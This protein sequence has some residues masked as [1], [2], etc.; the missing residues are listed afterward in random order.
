MARKRVVTRTIEECM[1]E[2]KV[3]YTIGDDDVVERETFSLGGQVD[4]KKALT[5]A[6]NLYNRPASKGVDENGKEIDIPE[7]TIAKVIRF[8][9]E[10]Q[11]Y[12][13]LETDFIQ[14]A[15][16]MDA[17]RKFI[18]DDGEVIQAD[19]GE[20]DATSEPAKEEPAEPAKEKP[21]KK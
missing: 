1:V 12:G 14:L 2:C 17:E 16:K 5:L 11:I 18:T 4:E 6:Q 21:N 8:Y 19:D 3:V 9:K 10:Q 13:M 7:R 20:N 15:H